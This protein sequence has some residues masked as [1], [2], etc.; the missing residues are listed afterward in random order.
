MATFPKLHTY[1]AQVTWTGDLGSGTSG[2]R[3]YERSHEVSAEGRPPIPGSSDPAFRGDPARWNPEQLLLASISQ[4]HLLWYLHF[5]AVNG[6]VV[7][8]Y[9]DDPVGTMAET[10]EGGHFTEAVLHPR[11][12]VAEASMAERAVALHEDAHR[13]CFIAN[14]V[15]FPVRHEPTVSV[16]S[17]V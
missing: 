6:V 15:N 7:T 17:T 5:C 12:E 16:R 4:C 14:S 9:V 13:A 1:T 2:Y 8:A 3:A 11:I 10:A